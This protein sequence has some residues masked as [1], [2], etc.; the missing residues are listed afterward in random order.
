MAA[1]LNITNATT[2]SVATEPQRLG[3]DFRFGTRK[4][5]TVEVV[6][7]DT[8]N[9]VGIG[10][11]AD[12]ADALRKTKN[13]DSLTING[14]D[15]GRAKLIDFN[16][17]EGNWV[18]YTKCTLTLQ[19]YEEG[20]LADMRG[21]SYKGLD[22]IKEN[23]EFLDDYSEDFSFER[24]PDSTTYTY[25][26]TLDFSA[27]AQISTSDPCIGGEVKLA[28][29]CA[30][31]MIKAPGS[32]RPSFALISEEVKDLYSD[33]AKGKKRLLRESVD[34]INKNCTFTEE[35]KAY[36][37]ADSSDEYSSIIRQSLTLGEDGI[38]TVK[39]NGK[40]LGL[41]T[42][43]SDEIQ[44]KLPLV[45]DEISSAVASGGRL[46]KMFENYKENWD[47]GAVDDL[48]KDD[49]GS[50]L[51]IIKK[52]VVSD[53]FKGEATYDIT[54]TNNQKY[55]EMVIHEYSVVTESV[56]GQKGKVYRATE[57]GTITGMTVG[58]VEKDL[59]DDGDISWDKVMEYWNDL[60]GNNGFVESSGG[61]PLIKDILDNPSPRLVSNSTV[62]SPRRVQ[63]TYSQMVS[64]ESQ[65]A[66]N[67][68]D[69]KSITLQESRTGSVQK[70]KVGDVINASR[71]ILQKRHTFS[72]N[73]IVGNLE[74]VGKRHA[75]LDTLLDLAKTKLTTAS[76]WPSEKNPE[77]DYTY[78][79]NCTYSFSD[80]NDIKLNL[81]IGWE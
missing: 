36:N 66:D 50:D 7:L 55:T 59:N 63:I 46:V 79:N 26:L 68:G 12:D 27:A 22:Y 58:E 64:E 29:D 32:A 30:K 71:Q 4:N 35:F 2:L 77:N 62:K 69:A 5:I 40:L 60:L 72:A 45:D 34:L 47:C 21:D 8:V 25:S 44:R 1:T 13:W 67:D 74:I 61:T 73:D 65:F 38:V 14:I 54:C 23:G 43:K 56:K 52:G 51:L 78:I 9:A 10:E 70:H 3:S 28:Y 31:E 11:C 80:D 20:D 16:L 57:N 39:E 48:V 18:Q 33:Y 37:I 15:F 19:V 75:S 17:Q 53:S 76:Y 6:S 42:I 41:D 24:S 49:G 81:K